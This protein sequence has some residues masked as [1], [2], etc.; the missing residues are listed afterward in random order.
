MHSNVEAVVKGMHKDVDN[1][2]KFENGIVCCFVLDIFSST[3][4]LLTQLTHRPKTP[5]RGQGVCSL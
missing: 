5:I 4:Y 2:P 1:Q 3:Y